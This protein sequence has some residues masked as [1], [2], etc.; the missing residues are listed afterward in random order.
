M[1]KVFSFAGLALLL[2]LAVPGGFARTP[3][4]SG[5]STIVIVFKDGHR[6]SFNLSEVARVEFGGA[7]DVAEA[8]AASNQL[9]RQFV[10]RWEC[11]DGNGQNFYITLREDGTAV[12]SHGNVHGRWV[13]AN[14]E[15]EVTWD[16]GVHDALRKVGSGY[17]K[18]AFGAMKSFTDNPDNVANAQNTT[19]HPL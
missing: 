3:A 9:P 1:R 10:G 15:A 8:A 16:D 13:F 4:K 17:E 2:C 6:Q 18:R 7:A 5:P 11:G 19:P 14:G 12:R